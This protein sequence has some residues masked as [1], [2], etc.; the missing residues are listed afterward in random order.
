MFEFIKSLPEIITASGVNE[1]TFLTFLFVLLFF[2]LW[3]LSRKA[4]DKI[5]VFVFLP[6]LV[7]TAFVIVVL[8][9]THVALS[10]R[11]HVSTTPDSSG[12]SSTTSTASGDGARAASSPDVP[13]ATAKATPAARITGRGHTD[14]DAMSTVGSAT[15]TPAAGRD[16]RA[17]IIAVDEALWSAYQAHDPKPYI[18]H[19]ADDY[20][21]TAPDGTTNGKD[22][23]IK[24]LAMDYIV[25][26][27]SLSLDSLDIAGNGAWLKGRVWKQRLVQGKEVK[28][29]YSFTH[30]YQKRNGRWQLRARQVKL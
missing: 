4:S 19:I 29:A 20:I 13:T 8:I 7:L 23:A 10:I 27:E 17:T 30:V 1:R 15:R 28:G 14:A 2:V 9:V 22:E 3:L 26:V 12:S 5:K 6:P 16:D 21:E 24:S 11:T 18:E 25:R